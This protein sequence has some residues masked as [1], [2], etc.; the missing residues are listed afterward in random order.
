MALQNVGR[1]ASDVEHPWQRTHTVSVQ[2]A[3]RQHR[4]GDRVGRGTES[5]PVLRAA[6]RRPHDLLWRDT[7]LRVEGSHSRA[8]TADAPSEDRPS[9]PHY[10]AWAL[11]RAAANCSS[12]PA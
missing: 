5:G 2:R 7:V 9:R 8:L 3:G 10:R 11:R 4:W 1:R 12:T 6:Y